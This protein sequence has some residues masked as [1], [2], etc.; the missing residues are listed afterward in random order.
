M[1]IQKPP[2]AEPSRASLPS[3][4]EIAR[5]VLAGETALFE[6]LM[7]RYNQR[8]YRAIRSLLKEEVEIE[9]ALQQTYIQAFTHLSQFQGGAQFSTWFTRIAL[10]EALQRLRQR[11]RWVAMDGG[12]DHSAEEHMKLPPR[13]EPSPEQQA[14]GREL[15]RLLE[16]T[17]DE[18]PDIYRTV[19]MLRE[20][21]R[22]STT[23]TAEILSVKEDV[24][25]Q[26]LHRAKAFIRE[27][28]DAH[29]GGSLTE[30]FSFHASRCDRVV[31]AVLERLGSSQPS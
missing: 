1:R 28:M 24:V 7:R 23:E 16:L 25:K 6:V 12:D 15:A 27:R 21:E 9:D 14:F 11:H 30:A 10:N 13:N 31:A 26:R 17:I 5:R 2:A 4:E 18:L 29:L 22:M 20:V 8:L 19:F 3:D